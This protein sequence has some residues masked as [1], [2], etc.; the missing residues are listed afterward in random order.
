MLCGGF[1]FIRR[2]YFR[3]LYKP[4]RHTCVYIKKHLA[5]I[6]QRNSYNYSGALIMLGKYSKIDA[7]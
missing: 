7:H 6:H 1:D 4:G 3:D 2:G 5:C